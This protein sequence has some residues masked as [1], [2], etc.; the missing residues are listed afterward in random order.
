MNCRRIDAWKKQNGKVALQL[1]YVRFILSSL[2]LPY[3]RGRAAVASSVATCV[4]LAS[5]QVHMRAADIGERR[6]HRSFARPCING[7]AGWN[8][9]MTAALCRRREDDIIRLHRKSASLR[10]LAPKSVVAD[11]LS[12]L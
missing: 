10:R 3:L 12:R 5:R 1:G 9:A 2:L 4:Q 6:C 8:S 7:A 11:T